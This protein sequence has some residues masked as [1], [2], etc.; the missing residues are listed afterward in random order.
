MLKVTHIENRGDDEIRYGYVYLSDG[1][2]VLYRTVE[3][4]QVVTRS[5]GG[6]YAGEPNRHEHTTTAQDALDEHAKR[7]AAQTQGERGVEVTED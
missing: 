4:K 2:R 3:G 1:H 5:S 6:W 7:R